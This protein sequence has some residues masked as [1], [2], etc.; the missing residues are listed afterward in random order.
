MARRRYEIS[1]ETAL[2]WVER[3]QRGGSFTKIGLHEGYDRRLVAKTVRTYQRRQHQEEGAVTLRD[4][5]AGFL[6]EHLEDLQMVATIL[7]ELTAGP[8][9][10]HQLYL[11]HSNIESELL[12]RVK[13]VV[14]LRIAIPPDRSILDNVY[15]EFRDQV[16]KHMAKRRARVLVDDLKQHLPDLWKQVEAWEEVTVR[17]EASWRKLAKQAEDSGIVPDLFESGL[18][19]G[20]NFMSKAY[21][22]ED[23][24]R[25]PTKLETASDVGQWLFQ[26]PTTRESLESFHHNLEEL[27]AA[28]AQLEDALNPF[29]LRKALLARQC[30]HCP[31][32]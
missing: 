31:L 27:E 9:V 23:L 20:L 19:E 4:V 14:A 6:R 3:H 17:Y 28:Y 12:A 13:E 26:N 16:T 21:E 1:D 8:S 7:L 24:P 2:R 15:R 30:K 32:P 22:E 5:R 25:T 10:W 29:E 11:C 18:R